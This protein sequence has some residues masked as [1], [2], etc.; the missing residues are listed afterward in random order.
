MPGHAIQKSLLPFEALFAAAPLPGSL[1][2]QSD[3]LMLAVND[4]WVELTGLS[5]D[6]VI[7]RRT[8]EFGFWVDPEDRA[9]YVAELPNTHSRHL[10][11]FKGGAGAPRAASLDRP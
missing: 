4:A 7:G 10:L 6:Q 3:G 5:R 1:A 11:R 8:S 9:R 2:R